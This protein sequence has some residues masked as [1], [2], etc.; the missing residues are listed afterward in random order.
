M[1][2]FRLCNS[3]T[4]VVAYCSVAGYGQMDQTVAK[5]LRPFQL[6]VAAISTRPLMQQHEYIVRLS[7]GLMSSD[8]A[9]VAGQRDLPNFGH[10]AEELINQ[11]KFELLRALIERQELNS[12]NYYSVAELLAM[13]FDDSTFHI[14]ITNSS[15]TMPTLPD[16][17]GDKAR[18]GIVT[19]E[20]IPEYSALSLAHYIENGT[21]RSQVESHLIRILKE[22]KRNGVRAFAARALSKSKSA[23]AIKALEEATHDK[24]RVITDQGEFDSV[25]EYAQEALKRI[26][27]Q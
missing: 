23:A 3:I 18:E 8:Y 7:R 13:K 24:G 1:S 20:G 5:S 21:T 22:H 14:L 12:Y 16:N 15:P 2:I 11:Q 17:E 26:K 10:L 25:N 9:A 19:G 6:I 27:G 4:L